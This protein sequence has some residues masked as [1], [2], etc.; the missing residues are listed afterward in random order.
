MSKVEVVVAAMNQIDLSLVQKM[1]IQSDIV[2]ANQ[3][4]RYSFEETEVNGN[5][6]RMLT[7]A[8]RGV[9]RNRNFGLQVATGDILMLADEDIVYHDGYAKRIESAF[10]EL[11]WADVI[12]FRMQFIKNGNVYE[13]DHH[14]TRRV[15]LWNGLS[16]GTYQIAIR[17]NSLLRENIHFSEL[18][19]GG[20]LYSAGEDSLFLIDCFRKGLRIYSHNALIGDNIRDSSSWFSG[21]H[22]KFFY[23]RGAFL[24]CAF[25]KM[26]IIVPFYYLF[27]YRKTKELML[28]QKICLMFAGVRGGHSLQSY[29]EW[30]RACNNIEE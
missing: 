8:T 29:E 16:F 21:F 28:R 3:A 7:T 22:E 4:D 5:R 13:V 24:A 23:D 27:V 17:R 1:N 14:A 19:G 9:G 30:Q 15:H 11:P 10:E 2:I 18:F 20:C 26:K 12:V 6:V 25:P